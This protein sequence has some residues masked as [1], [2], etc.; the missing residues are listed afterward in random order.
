MLF[1]ANL[2]LLNPGRQP[3]VCRPLGNEDKYMN[4]DTAPLFPAQASNFQ[5]SF[6]ERTDDDRKVR[7]A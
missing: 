3:A 5:G 2:F 6:P 7:I 4:E 1:K